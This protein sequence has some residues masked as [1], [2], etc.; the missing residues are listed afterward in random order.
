MAKRYSAFLA[1]KRQ[2]PRQ[3]PRFCQRQP[4]I[5]EYQNPRIPKPVLWVFSCKNAISG[6]ALVIAAPLA[7]FLYG[8][9]IPTTKRSSTAVWRPGPA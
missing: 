9:K 7:V 5:P 1:Q 4:R 6:N 2:S 3:E 8:G